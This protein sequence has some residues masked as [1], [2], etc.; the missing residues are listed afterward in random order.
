M[1]QRICDPSL[2][3]KLQRRASGKLNKA[4][5]DMSGYR[6]LKTH[7][8]STLLARGPLSAMSAFANHTV[9]FIDGAW[10]IITPKETTLMSTSQMDRNWTPLLSKLDFGTSA[11]MQYKIKQGISK[12]S[13]LSKFSL[14]CSLLRCVL[15]G[16]DLTLGSVV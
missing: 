8:C 4:L 9:H 12:Q 13:Q 1:G 16:R 14:F 10:G 6:D 15:R 7:I 11:Q 3:A 2:S 5:K